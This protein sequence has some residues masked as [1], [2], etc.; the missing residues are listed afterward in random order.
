V[1]SES[2]M[3][4]VAN[5]QVSSASAHERLTQHFLKPH[6]PVL[7][8]GHHHCQSWSAP[9]P[10]V[11]SITG[12]RSPD[13]HISSLSDRFEKRKFLIIEAH[14]KCGKQFLVWTVSQSLN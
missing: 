7:E 6:D 12:G 14:E 5:N 1:L 2:R 13:W 11:Q 10:R 3:R 9:S 4:T 8:K